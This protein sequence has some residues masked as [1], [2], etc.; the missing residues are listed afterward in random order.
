M[1]ALN[2]DQDFTLPV[3]ATGTWFLVFE[4]F[5]LNQALSNPDVFNPQA[6]FNY[7]NK[8]WAL[9]DRTVSNMLEQTPIFLSTL[10]C[11]ALFIDAEF[12]GRMGIAAAIF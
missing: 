6:R 12:A 8:V 5:I 3:L 11:H 10:W 1:L 2:V 9:A 7:A 4:L